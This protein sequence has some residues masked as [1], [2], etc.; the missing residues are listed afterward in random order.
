M[1]SESGFT[2]D[3]EALS[4]EHAADLD[5]VISEI[6]GKYYWTSNDNREMV[7]IESSVFVTYLEVGGLGYVRTIAPRMKAVASVMSHTEEKFDYVEHHVLGLRS[8]TFYG[9]TR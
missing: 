3:A 7:R 1:V 9:T 6:G 4:R 8:N 2:R 5:C